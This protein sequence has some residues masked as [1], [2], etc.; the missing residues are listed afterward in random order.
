M[1]GRRL[2]HRPRAPR[3]LL[4]SPHHPPAPEAPSGAG[5]ALTSAPLSAR[6][7]TLAGDPGS[8][9][10]KMPLEMSA[11]RSAGPQGF[12]DAHA[13]N[14]RACTEADAD[15]YGRHDAG[16]S[17]PYV[18]I[19]C[20]DSRVSPYRCLGPGQVFVQRNVGNQVKNQDG[21]MSAVDYSIMALGAKHVV[22][23]GHSKCGA[24]KA[25]MGTDEEF[26]GLPPSVAGWIQGIRDHYLEVKAEVD[27]AADPLQAMCVKNVEKQVATMKAKMEEDG[28]A[29]KYGATVTGVMYQLA[30]GS[31]TSVC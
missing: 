24:V 30:D 14:C 10:A 20:S 8:A 31:M 1:A 5:L 28:L 6:G 27:A 9:A 13:E 22:V 16:Q 29:A 18:Y 12:L 7:S 2:P 15:Y 17:P 23:A 4:L 3:D 26:A 11:A 21:I 19:G 25:A